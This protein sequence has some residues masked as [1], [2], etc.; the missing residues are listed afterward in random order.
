MERTS[1]LKGLVVIVLSAILVANLVSVVFADNSSV[2]ADGWDTELSVVNNTTTNSSTNTSTGVSTTNT[3]TNTSTNTGSATTSLNT[4]N[5]NEENE[6]NS[7]A[8][9]G[10]ESNSI[11]AIVLVLG[12]I[13]ATYS[14]K[15]VK[16]YNEI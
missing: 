2:D 3:T 13:V 7:L 5:S 10:V 6:V 14:L 12:V 8:Y 16:E 15:K 1:L 11:L 9:T 4:S